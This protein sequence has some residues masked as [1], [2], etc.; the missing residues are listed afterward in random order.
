M[1]YI[2][3]YGRYTDPREMGVVADQCPHCDRLSPCSI[4]G[5][6]RRTHLYFITFSEHVAS[7]E[8]CCGACGNRFPREVGQYREIV[9]AGEA[10]TMMIETLLERTNP[11][12]KDRLLWAQQRRALAEDERFES[13]NQSIEQLRPGPLRT[14]LQEALRQWGQLSEEQRTELRHTAT[15]SVRA[16]HFAESV[17]S[18]LPGPVGCL[19]ACLACLAV[20]SAFL[21]TSAGRRLLW[22]V[23][24]VFAGF[25]AGAVVLQHLFNRRVRRWTREVLIPEGETWGVDFGRLIA[26]LK[27]LADSSYRARDELDGWRANARTLIKGLVAAGKGGKD[28]P[29]QGIA[30]TPSHGESGGNQT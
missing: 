3:I 2:L 4:T 12:L 19:P 7:G 17:A 27:D 30:L 5:Y 28:K 26:I 20:W 18:Q 24:L 13:A 23:A 9:P 8:C 16:L 14:E 25:A 10:A 6:Y 11:D 1:W 22:S 29:A 15:E 21:W